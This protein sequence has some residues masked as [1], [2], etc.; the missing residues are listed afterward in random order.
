MNRSSSRSWWE[1]AVVGAA[2][3]SLVWLMVFGY[4]LDA[5]A[6]GR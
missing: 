1:G 2:L 3:I 4:V 6:G 5:L